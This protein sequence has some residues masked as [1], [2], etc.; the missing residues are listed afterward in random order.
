MC[1]FST[2]ALTDKSVWLGS[3]SVNSF[4]ARKGVAEDKTSEAVSDADEE[5]GEPSPSAFKTKAGS[6]TWVSLSEKYI[7]IISLRYRLLFACPTSTRSRETNLK[8]E[9]R[10]TRGVGCG[11]RLSHNPDLRRIAGSKIFVYM[12]R[13]EQKN[14]ILFFFEKRSIVLQFAVRWWSCANKAS[15]KSTASEKSILYHEQSPTLISACDDRSRQSREIWSV[16][17]VGHFWFGRSS[18]AISLSTSG[19]LFGA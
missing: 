10:R 6:I 2:T 17:P 19:V 9:R 7:T 16:F 15:G 18:P 12:S 5:T 14:P 8:G 13:Y 3:S 1:L 11:R 4:G